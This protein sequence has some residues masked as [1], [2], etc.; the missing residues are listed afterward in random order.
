MHEPHVFVALY[1]GQTIAEA[2]IVGASTDPELVRF[3][4]DR[5]RTDPEDAPGSRPYGRGRFAEA[6]ALLLRLCSGPR[7]AAQKGRRP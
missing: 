1:T 7:R 5:M 3:A 4:A 6:A 2:R